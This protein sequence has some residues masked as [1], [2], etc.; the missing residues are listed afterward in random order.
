MKKTKTTEEFIEEVKAKYGDKY[1]CSKVEYINNS[2]KVCIICPIHG[3]FWITPNHFLSGTECAECSK[4]KI[5]QKLTMSEDEF[6]RRAREIHGDNYDYSKVRYT[7]SHTEVC[8]ICPIHGEFW[9]KPSKHLYGQGCPK[10]SGKGKTTE[11]FIRE[12]RQIH[13]DKYDYSKVIYIDALTKVCII[14]PIHGEFWQR[15]HDHLTGKQ[16]CPKCLMSKSEEEIYNFLND[17][18]IDFIYQ[19]S[20][21][22]FKWLGKQRIDFFLPKYNIAI[23]CQGIQHFKSKDFFGGEEGLKTILKL[24]ER[25]RKLCLE[26]NIKTIYYANFQYNFP[27]F[28]FT[29]KDNL[30]KEIEQHGTN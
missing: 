3:E 20:K 30:L 18:R 24:D 25:K 6:I 19:A 21:K 28:V 4:E 7:N 11:D 22:D 12:A 10:C 26:N 9:Q 29:E 14:C 5:R 23:E 8:I 16:G 27:Y 2:T 13:G 17:N 1:D 15:P